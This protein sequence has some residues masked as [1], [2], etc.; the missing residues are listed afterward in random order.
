MNDS[1]VKHKQSSSPPILRPLKRKF[2]T[3]TNPHEPTFNSS[4]NNFVH[5]NGRSLYI[6]VRWI[7]VVEEKKGPIGRVKS[8]PFRL[9]RQL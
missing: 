9:Q 6:V 7:V 2:E 5:V 1:G 8:K 4:T 3:G